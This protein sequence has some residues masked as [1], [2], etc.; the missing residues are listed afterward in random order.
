MSDALLSLVRPEVLDLEPYSSARGAAALDGQRVFLDANESPWAPGDRPD[1]RDLNRYPEPQP[2]VLVEGLAEIHGV[3]AER[4]LL[5]RGVDEGIDL[6]LRAFCRP[7]RDG[8]LVCPPTYG[9]YAISAAI[10]GARVVE[11]PYGRTATGFALDGGAVEAAARAGADPVKLVFLCSPNNPTGQA[12][13]VDEVLGLCEA[14]TDRALVVLD[15]AY[16]EFSA[17][18]SLVGR[19]GGEV[20]NLVVLRTLSKAWGL[21]GARLGA[22]FAAPVVIDVLRRIAA[23]Y[24]L[25]LPAVRAA[26]PHVT[27]AGW[28]RV[29]QRVARLVAER[30]G[31]AA[32]LAEITDVREVFPSDAN[33][34]LVRVED[35]GAFVER[36]AGAGILVRDRSREHGLDGCVRVSVGAPEENAR[37]LAALE[38]GDPA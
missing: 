23:P 17:V 11:V 13:A 25:C 34:L 7:G 20:P 21:A 15:E 16:A 4:I 3:P 24:P 2:R 31:L 19:A 12:I 5:G 1:D 27:P 29:K 6:L 36:C 28:G 37:L 38:R 26:A 33:F 9:M 18:P 35:P 30:H 10:Q 22:T 8:I 14:L 32:A